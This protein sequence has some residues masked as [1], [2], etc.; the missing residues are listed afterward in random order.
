[1]G[2]CKVCNPGRNWQHILSDETVAEIR[3]LQQSTDHLSK[4]HPDRWTYRKLA[5]K[6]G[7]NKTTIEEIVSYKTYEWVK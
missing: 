2:L 7:I 6:F 1:M 4:R 3:Q 5:E